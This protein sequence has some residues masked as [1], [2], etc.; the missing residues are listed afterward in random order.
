MANTMA[1]IASLAAA[2]NACKAL[3][4]SGIRGLHLRLVWRI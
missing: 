4:G 2:A 3:T 1:T